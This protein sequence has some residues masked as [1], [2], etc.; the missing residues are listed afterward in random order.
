MGYYLAYVVIIFRAVRGS[1]TIGDLTFLAGSF[2]QLRGLL[3]GILSRF[4]SV[5]QGAI[6]LQDLFEFFEIKPRIVKVAMP[7]P[8]PRPIRAA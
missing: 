3:E 7:R 5:S 1:L 4:T 8:F 6:Y 2:R